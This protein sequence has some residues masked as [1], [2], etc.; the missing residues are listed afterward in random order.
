MTLQN[1]SAEQHDV[2]MRN[3]TEHLRLTATANDAN[4]ERIAMNIEC[5]HIQKTL[6]EEDLTATEYLSL[7][8]WENT[9]NPQKGFASSARLTEDERVTLGKWLK[10]NMKLLDNADQRLGDRIDADDVRFPDERINLTELNAVSKAGKWPN[11]KQLNSD[12]LLQIDRAIKILDQFNASKD[13]F[14]LAV[15]DDLISGAKLENEQGGVQAT[16]ADGTITFHKSNGLSITK[17]PNGDLIIRPDNEGEYVMRPNGTGTMRTWMEGLHEL[18]TELPMLR[19]EDGT[20]VI[21]NEDGEEMITLKA[22]PSRH[23]VKLT[24]IEGDSVDFNV[25]GMTMTLKQSGVDSTITSDYKT[26]R[27]SLE[28]EGQKLVLDSK[29]GISSSESSDGRKR[30]ELD[31]GVSVE[32]DKKGS[33]IVSTES[34][35]IVETGPNGVPTLSIN[36]TNIQLTLRADG[37][38]FYKSDNLRINVHS[39]GTINLTDQKGQ[40]VV[41]QNTLLSIQR[42]ISGKF[43]TQRINL[44]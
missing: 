22:D 40:I 12:D 17:C 35:V 15:I 4:R 20:W 6:P 39:D 28:E 31:G 32:R 9:H 2:L 21:K 16:R 30:Y 8:T 34:G 26:G 10:S 1:T 29:Q 41:Y 23:T 19:K 13:G 43:K 42:E 5:T 18:A 27:I 36:G 37:S 24:T 3:L 7:I 44:Y 11:G 14:T 25:K 33:T 38:H